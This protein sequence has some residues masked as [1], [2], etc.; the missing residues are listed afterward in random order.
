[1]TNDT[2]ERMALLM[3]EM[4]RAGELNRVKFLWY[5]IPDPRLQ[6]LM[7]KTLGFSFD[8][9]K[10]NPMRELSMA[11]KRYQ[12]K[13]KHETIDELWEAREGFLGMQK[14]VGAAPLMAKIMK[15]PVFKSLVM[16]GYWNNRSVKNIE[17]MFLYLM[18]HFMNNAYKPDVEPPE[19][20]K[21]EGIGRTGEH[22]AGQIQRDIMVDGADQ[23]RLG[24]GCQQMPA[25]NEVGVEDGGHRADDADAAL[26]PGRDRRVERRMIPFDEKRVVGDETDALPGVDAVC[27]KIPPR[28]P[29]P[30]WRRRSSAS[31]P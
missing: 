19:K 31:P 3:T 16:I 17:N 29:R 20:V 18:K 9:N 2:V 12:A 27:L 6:Q 7:F 8:M 23:R 11:I 25:G 13:S 26:L 15:K 14:M 28:C 1:M 4:D 24:F 5:D 30:I 21:N 10:S 22:R